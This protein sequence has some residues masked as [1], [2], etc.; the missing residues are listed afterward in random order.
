LSDLSGRKPLV[1]L[2]A[3]AVEMPVRSF[4]RLERFV[5]NQHREN[6]GLS[7]ADH[8]QELTSAFLQCPTTALIK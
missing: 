8:W 5:K 4:S 2:M 1:M 6:I 7:I 3:F